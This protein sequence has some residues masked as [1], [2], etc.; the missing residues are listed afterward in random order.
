MIRNLLNRLL[1]KLRSIFVHSVR[2]HL[3]EN[4]AR[5][6]EDL[7]FLFDRFLKRR[8]NYDLE[9]D[10]FISWENENPHVEQIRNE[11]GKW[12][13]LLFSNREAEKSL[14]RE[15][16]R[17]ERDRLAALLNL[18]LSDNNADYLVNEVE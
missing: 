18:S 1:E 4:P 9:W 13:P 7:V 2:V 3:H 11:L 10:D 14:Y 12:E 16:V 17:E 5:D 6:V 15:K 8:M